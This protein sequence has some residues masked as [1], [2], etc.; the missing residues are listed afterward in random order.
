MKGKTRWITA[1]TISVILIAVQ[2]YAQPTGTTIT[3]NQTDAPEGASPAS[4][5]DSGGSIT[6]LVVD[7]LQQN[8]RWKAYIGN[9]TGSLTLDDSGGNTIFNWALDQSEITGEIYSSRNDSVSWT[10]IQ[11]AANAMIT[12]E[13]SFLGMSS[14]APDSISNTFNETTHPALTIGTVNI[15]ANTCNATSTFVNDARQ[16][17]ATADFPLILLDDT[18]NLVYVSPINPETTGY[19][20]STFDFQLILAN[21]PSSTTPYYFYVELG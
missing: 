7:A 20:G 12:T 3:F 11:C 16:P 2:A 8:P 4:R 9:I 10:N 18:T 17:Q 21:N 15:L 13:E 19:D 6:T 5:T 1:L 14:A